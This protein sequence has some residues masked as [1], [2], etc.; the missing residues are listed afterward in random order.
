MVNPL[1]YFRIWFRDLPD[2]KKYVEVITASLSIP[3]LLSVVL[4][5]YFNIQEKRS[6]D[7]IVPTITQEKQTNQSP[8]IITIIQKP[9]ESATPFP[10]IPISPTQSITNEEC[11]KDIGPITITTPEENEI[12]SENP[13]A[14]DIRYDQGDYCSVVWS[15]RINKSKWSEYIDDNILIY[16]MDSGVKTLEL[17]VKSIVSDA[18]KNIKRTFIYEN[19]SIVISPTLTPTPS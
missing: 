10:T 19:T 6:R 3:V 13:L 7:T 2:K 18:N 9:D 17:R 14:I 15:Y 5:N 1:K 16:N 8:T 4:V 12:V 11:I